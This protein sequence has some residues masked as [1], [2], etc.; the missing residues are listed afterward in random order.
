MNVISSKVVR[1]CFD[2]SYK[3]QY[4]KSY[5]AEVQLQPEVTIT[6]H[7]LPSFMPL[8]QLN[9]KLQ[10][11]IQDFAYTTR[12]Y[13]QSYV[14]R[15]ESVKECYVRFLFEFVPCENCVVKERE[16]INKPL[17]FLSYICGKGAT[18]IRSC[19]LKSLDDVYHLS[20]N[21]CNF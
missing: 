21:F 5:Y 16:K 2:T 6:R 18:S 7:T 20:C 12:S 4:H 9:E 11:D 10:K 15:R 17:P 14:A 13:L 19:K 1:F 8:T 3:D